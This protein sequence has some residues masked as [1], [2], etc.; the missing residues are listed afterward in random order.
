MDTIIGKNNK[1]A[2]LQLMKEK[3]GGYGHTSCQVRKLNMW[4]Q[5]P[6]NY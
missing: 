3:P 6:C 4:R 5:Q 1:G 2:I